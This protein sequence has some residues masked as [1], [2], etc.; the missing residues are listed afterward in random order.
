MI[1]YVEGFQQTV[2]GFGLG[3]IIELTMD[4]IATVD[5]TQPSGFSS[6]HGPTEGMIFLQVLERISCDNLQQFMEI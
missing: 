1:R 5:S 3:D 2:L 4:Y 6:K